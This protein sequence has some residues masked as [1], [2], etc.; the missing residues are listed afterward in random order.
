[1]RQLVIF[2]VL[3]ATFYNV[4]TWSE[5]CS[6]RVDPGTGEEV[7]VRLYYDQVQDKCVP[8]RYRGMGGNENRFLTDQMCMRNC[9]SKAAELYPLD[10]KVACSFKKHHGDCHSHHL[11][12]YYDSAQAKCKKFHYTGCGGNGNK[13]IDERTCNTTCSGIH[14]DGEADEEDTDTPV[15]MIIGIVLGVIGT[16]IIIVV[17]VLTVKKK[18]TKKKAK[19][20][21]KEDN[22]PL[23]EEAVEMS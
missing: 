5:F 11:V 16:V 13:F 20:A 18:P 8:F 22:P 3:L 6:L 17:I 14:G 1:M 12:W 9:S 23:A 10:E 2:A 7:L 21:A 19:M 4:Q 15:G